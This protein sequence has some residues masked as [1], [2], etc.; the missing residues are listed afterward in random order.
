LLEG[1]DMNFVGPRGRTGGTSDIM[2]R[3]HVDFIKGG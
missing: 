3:K 1:G 2:R